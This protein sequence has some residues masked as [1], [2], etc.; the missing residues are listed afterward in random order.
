MTCLRQAGLVGSD[1]DDGAVQLLDLDAQLVDSDLEP[2]RVFASGDLRSE[3]TLTS[4]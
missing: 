4:L 3:T 2:F 1:V